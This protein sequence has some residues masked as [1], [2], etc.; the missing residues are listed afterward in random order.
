MDKTHTA[1]TQRARRETAVLTL[2][3]TSVNSTGMS[4]LTGMA[5]FMKV[6]HH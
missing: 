5:V 1:E 3:R 6:A 4:S 2:T